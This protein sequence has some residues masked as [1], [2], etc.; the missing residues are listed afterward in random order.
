MSTII[1]VIT[2]P[3]PEKIRVGDYVTLRRTGGPYSNEVRGTVH[4]WDPIYADWLTFKGWP[5]QRFAI[6][7]DHAQWSIAR[8]QREETVHADDVPFVTG[9]ATVSRRVPGE[10]RDVRMP[11]RERG[12]YMAGRF[13]PI[14][15][16]G[17][18]LPPAE[19]FDFVK[20]PA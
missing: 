3:S 2:D 19:W 15:A 16:D 5:N 20:D 1:R 8:I 7:G 17:R 13:Y 9:T 18:P 12:I 6:D 10:R 4:R 14:G 11:H